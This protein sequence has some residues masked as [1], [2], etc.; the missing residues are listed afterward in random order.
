[1]ADEARDRVL[2][3][4]GGGSGIGA[5]VARGA[6]ALDWRVVITGRRAEALRRVADSAP[7]VLAMPADMSE[8]EAVAGVVSQVAERWGRLDVV[9][10]NAG[11]M[12]EG[13]AAGT[14]P[15][16]WRR[17]LDVNLTGPYL[18]AREAMPLLR[19][20]RGSFI[21]VGSI[22]GLRVPA[23]AAA[24]AVSK[25]ALDMLVRTIAV[26][27]GPHGVRANIVCPGWV[28]TE[29]A[30]GEM[31]SFG[32]PLG[33]DE[34]GAYAEVS[35]LVPLGRPALPDEVAGA[36]LWLAGAEAS[37]ITGASL[38]VDGGTTLVDPGTVPLSFRVERRVMPENP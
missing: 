4:T 14:D 15:S 20:S 17:V 9:V 24:Y 12:H 35:R 36:V 33:L 6:A 16:D 37:Y 23:G 32:G 28:R 21:A 5:A 18:L 11:V 8:P 3:I 27:E 1:M 7:G 25:A 34:E 31:A 38:T 10:A 22:A 2:L 26:D 19:G 13:S 29:M 30:D